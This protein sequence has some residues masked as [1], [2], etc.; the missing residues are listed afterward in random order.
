[1]S[2]DNQIMPRAGLEPARVAPHAP[3][4]C[5]STKFHHLGVGAEYGE[6][7]YGCQMKNTVNFPVSFRLTRLQ[8]STTLPPRFDNYHQT[9]GGND[10]KEGLQGGLVTY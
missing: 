5:V 8:V 9:T 2:L 3:Q 10:E 4:A 7:L 6:K 1:M